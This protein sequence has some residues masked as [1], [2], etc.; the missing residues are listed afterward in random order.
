VIIPAFFDLGT[1]CGFAVGQHGCLA[2]GEWKLQPTRFESWAMRLINFRRHLDAL[3]K[4]GAFTHVGYEEVRRHAGTDAA[5]CYG[6]LMGVLQVFCLEHS[7]PYE[8]V[9]V[10]TL[11]KFWTGK[12]NASKA[13]MIQVARDRG[14][15]L[16]TDNEAD[17]VAGWHWLAAAL[18]YE[19]PAEPAAAALEGADYKEAAE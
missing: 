12:A 11:K 19:P 16:K 6:A 17:A 3:Y 10:G 4:T 15:D 18:G 2:Y 13:E 1:T 7:I 5:H 8:G 9:G 14:F